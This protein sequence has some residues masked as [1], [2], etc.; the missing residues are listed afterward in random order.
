MYAI[1]LSD[2]A[3]VDLRW[4]RR[5]DQNRILDGIEAALR[6]QPTVE[7]RNLKRLR[8]NQTAEWKLRIG[9]FRVYYDVVESGR[10]VT[11]VAIGL[12][13][14]NRVFFGGPERTL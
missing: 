3:L 4:F 9:V 8:P 5:T 11:V 6:H 10:R 13:I 7:T 12:K 1:E 14:G 2:R